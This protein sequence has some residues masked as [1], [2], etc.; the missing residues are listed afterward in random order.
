MTFVFFPIKR[1]KNS[2]KFF[3]GRM[4]VYTYMDNFSQSNPKQQSVITDVVLK[5]K[6]GKLWLSFSVDHPE[7]PVRGPINF[8]INDFLTDRF[9]FYFYRI[10]AIQNDKNEFTILLNYAWSKVD[11]FKNFEGVARFSGTAPALLRAKTAPSI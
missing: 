2:R 8:N 9:D 10:E 3:N 11:Y 1:I 4:A 6:N 7:I 5:I